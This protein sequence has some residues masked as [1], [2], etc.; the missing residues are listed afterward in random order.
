M[1]SHHVIIMHFPHIHSASLI[2]FL[3]GNHKV[4]SFFV[5]YRLHHHHSKKNRSV[6]LRQS[7]QEWFCLDS[8]GEASPHLQPLNPSF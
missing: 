8:T 5:K 6:K 3:G 2:A 1:S 4:V 7:D